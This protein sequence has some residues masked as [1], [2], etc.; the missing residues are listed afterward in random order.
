V[1]DCA[2]AVAHGG[3]CGHSRLTQAR[4][5]RGMK[6]RSTVEQRVLHVKRVPFFKKS[7]WILSMTD[8]TST[9][10]REPNSSTDIFPPTVEERDDCQKALMQKLS[11]KISSILN[12]FSFAFWIEA[13]AKRYQLAVPS[14]LAN[15]ACQI[16]KRFEGQSQHIG[17]SSANVSTK[18]SR[19]ELLG[20]EWGCTCKHSQSRLPGRWQAQ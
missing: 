13:A 4:F 18:H 2:A 9:L 17:I 6:Y 20:T 11:P 19:S 14:Y 7:T 12:N 15:H 5:A 16:L 10:E 1:D 3:S 8:P